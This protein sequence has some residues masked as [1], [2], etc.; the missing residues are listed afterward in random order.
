LLLF[1]L[2]RVRRAGGS[3]VVF[4]QPAK[5]TTT[6]PIAAR[7]TARRGTGGAVMLYDTAGNETKVIPS[8]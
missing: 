1:I 6:P 7:L 5:A 3:L 2:W 8:K 4:S